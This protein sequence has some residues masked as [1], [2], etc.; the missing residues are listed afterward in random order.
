MG[1]ELE[2]IWAAGKALW[3]IKYYKESTLGGLLTDLRV[4][5]HRGLDAAACEAV[6][7]ALN[8]GVGISPNFSQNN[9]FRNFPLILTVFRERFESWSQFPRPGTPTDHIA[10]DHH[11]GHMQGLQ[12][13]LWSSITNS[14]RGTRSW[15]AELDALIEADRRDSV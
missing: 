2:T 1:Q 4:L 15:T 14:K 8:T 7:T 5:C 11:C 3:S 6:V 13:S 12:Q 10:R 9:I